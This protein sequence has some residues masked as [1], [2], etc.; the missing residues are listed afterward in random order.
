MIDFEDYDTANLPSFSRD[1][2]PEI[3]E[4]SSMCITDIFQNKYLAYFK[5]K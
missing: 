4:S 3:I 2:V 1:L 5:P